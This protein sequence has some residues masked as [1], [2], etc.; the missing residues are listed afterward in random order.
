VATSLIVKIKMALFELLICRQSST[1]QTIRFAISKPQYRDM[2][3]PK[4]RVAPTW[5]NRE[6]Q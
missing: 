2:G 1:E 4:R 6:V 5:L 3:H